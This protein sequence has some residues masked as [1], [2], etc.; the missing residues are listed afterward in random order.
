MSPEMQIIYWF[1]LK[2]LFKML[3]NG[4]Q[5]ALNTKKVGKKYE[6]HTSNPTVKRSKT[7]PGTP[8]VFAHF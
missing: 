6:N 8:S 4:L 1:S 2:C 5:N 3:T 7:T